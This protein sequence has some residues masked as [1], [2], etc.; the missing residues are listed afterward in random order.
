MA[1]LAA[2]SN[3]LYKAMLILSIIEN[4]RGYDV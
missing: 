3:E 2:Y 1:D 4:E